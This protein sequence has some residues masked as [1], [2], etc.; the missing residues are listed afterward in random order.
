LNG[1]EPADF[2][3]P[4]LIRFGN[5]AAVR[6]AGEAFLDQADAAVRFDLAALRENNSVVVALLLAWVRRADQ[7]GRSLLF[8]NVP[9]DLRNIIELYGVSGILP[10]DGAGSGSAWTVADDGPDAPQL[11]KV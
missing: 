4:E 10:L 8:V 3:V 6:H 7:L 1:A 5:A 9:A 2:P 11:E